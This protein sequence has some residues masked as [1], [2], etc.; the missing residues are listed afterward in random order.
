MKAVDLSI[1]IPT[2]NEVDNIDSLHKELL[3]VLKKFGRSYE[4]IFVDD[5]STDGTRGKL[6]K[7]ADSNT[8]IIFFRRNFGQTAALDAGFKHSKGAI[9]I[10]M[11]AD[12]QNDPADIPSLVNELEKGFDLVQ[13][14]RWN[15]QDPLNKKLFSKLSNW[16][17][18]KLTGEKVHDSGCTLRAIR[19]E[20]L[21]GLDLYGEM[22]RV[23]P[24]LLEWKGFKV[25]ELKVNHRQRK[26]GKSK[27]GI[28]RLLKGFLD[29]LV[30]TFWM[31]YSTR[32]VHLFGGFG[33]LFSFLGLVAGLYL[34]AL[35]FFR[36]EAIASR[37]LLSLA[38]LLVVLGV[39]LLLFGFITD[40]LVKGYY[41]GHPPYAIEKIA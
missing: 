8:H 22:H 18:K 36:N 23:I 26:S 3:S 9:V 5:G 24:A 15:R 34:L 20:A 2:F 12:L 17:R 39:Q 19:K 31:K 32:P 14:W 38:V 40:I 4:I 29:L 10:S 1:V 28:S 27:Y 6:Q 16:L 37:P 35:K 7:L 25:T 30:I 21:E 11:D 41:R 13:G 33:I